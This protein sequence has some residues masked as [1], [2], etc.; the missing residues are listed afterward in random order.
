MPKPSPNWKLSELK[1]YVRSH[2]LNHPAIKLS[3]N[4]ADL[5]KGLKTAG[6]W[7]TRQNLV[8]GGPKS[9]RTQP[10]ARGGPKSV[11][12]AK[13]VDKFMMKYGHL[14]K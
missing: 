4:K 1:D 14:A 6:H 7:D 13:L 10:T 8:R 3:M 12:N 11:R 2:K 9:K 5:I